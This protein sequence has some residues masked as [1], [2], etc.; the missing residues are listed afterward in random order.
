MLRWGH[1]LMDIWD[2]IVVGGGPAGSTT[3]LRLGEAGVRTLLIEKAAAFPR[4][5]PCGGGLSSRALTRFPYLKEVFGEIGVNS[6]RRVYLESPDGNSVL[7]EQA[8]PLMHLVRRWE[9]DAAL[10]R[11]AA[12]MIRIIWRITLTLTST[13]PSHGHTALARPRYSARGSTQCGYG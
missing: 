9:F 4:E 11:R 5:K 10:F 3:A 12:S 1:Q 8:E 13:T 7:H 2:V 6:I